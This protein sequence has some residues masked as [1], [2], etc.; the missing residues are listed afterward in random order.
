MKNEERIIGMLERMESEIKD[1]KSEMKDIKSEIKDV[2]T[3]LTAKIDHNF[4]VLND[5]I[6]QNFLTTNDKIDVL[7][8]NTKVRF[9]SIEKSEKDIKE[10]QKKEIIKLDE[11]YALKNKIEFRWTKKFIGFNAGISAIVAFFTTMWT[12]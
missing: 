7:A 6:D 1:V 9:N 8:E 5:K 4:K 3:R 12:K 10:V 2:E 11:I